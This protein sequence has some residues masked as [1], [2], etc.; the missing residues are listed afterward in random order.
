MANETNRSFFQLAFRFYGSH[1][2][3]ELAEGGFNS[4]LR[5]FETA[6]ERVNIGL[7]RVWNIEIFSPL[8]NYYHLY[9]LYGGWIHQGFQRKRCKR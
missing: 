6:I 7:H 9:F 8:E 4:A 2:N 5:L 1:Y 3:L